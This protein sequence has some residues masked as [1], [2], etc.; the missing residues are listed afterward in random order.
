[1]HSLIPPPEDDLAQLAKLTAERDTALHQRDTAIRTLRTLL[2]LVPPETFRP[3]NE[4]RHTTI[5]QRVRNELIRHFNAA[6]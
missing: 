1:M 2:A 4:H 5:L 3:K 6:Q